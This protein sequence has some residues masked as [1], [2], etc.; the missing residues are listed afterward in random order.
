MHCHGLNVCGS[1]HP[2]SCWNLIPN[3]LAF[4]NGAFGRWFHHGGALMNRELSRMFLLPCED[5]KK[6][7]VYEP[8]SR[9]PPVTESG[10]QPPEWW[11]IN[12]YCF[13]G[14]QSLWYF[15]IASEWTKNYAPRTMAQLKWRGFK[16][17]MV[18]MVKSFLFQYLTKYPI[19]FKTSTIIQK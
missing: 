8:G 16:Y 15:V 5:S 18:K 11:E 6:M 2:H 7:S 10:S 3:L 9:P 17:S 12:F 14:T 4:R 1:P 13:Q 19:K